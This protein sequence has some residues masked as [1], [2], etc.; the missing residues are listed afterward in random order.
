MGSNNVNKIYI[1]THND[2]DGMGGA[3]SILRILGKK[4]NDSVIIFAEPYNVENAIEGI[5]DSVNKGDYLFL[6]DIGS[7]KNNI[8][9]VYNY[10]KEISK[11]GVEIYWFDHHV[12]E[13]KDIQLI[14]SIGVNV[15][16]DTSTCG[17]GVA[18]KYASKIF[19]KNIDDFLEKLEKAICASD[20]WKWDDELGAK[21]FRATYANGGLNGLEWKFKVIDKFINGIIWDEELEEHLRYYIRKELEGYDRIL[22]TLK[23][24]GNSCKVSGVFKDTDIPSDSIV[25]AMILSRSNSDIAVI[26]K[27]KGFNLVS[28]SLR[29]RD[30]ANVQ[31]IAKSL[32]GGGH[33][34]ASG[35]SMNIPLYVSLIS[36]FDKSFLIKYVIKNIYSLALNNNSCLLNKK[37]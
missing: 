6:V 19:E 21:L 5:I 7:N 34:K 14:K 1:I 8:S 18:I 29:S 25:G 15:I 9:Y 32:G 10:F 23:T 20:I 27:K 12:W 28:L 35:A 36:L 4:L 11:K 2:L 13:D 24:Y 33:P 3:A 37:N 26:I 17:T 16:V 30:K 31:L 22:S